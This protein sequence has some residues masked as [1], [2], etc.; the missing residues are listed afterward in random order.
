MNVKTGV[1]RS[2]RLITFESDLAGVS[3]PVV[4]DVHSYKVGVLAVVASH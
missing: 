1:L 2:E 3:N 4:F